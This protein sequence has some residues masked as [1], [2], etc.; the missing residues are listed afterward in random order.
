[1]SSIDT[2]AAKYDL[3]H[4]TGKRLAMFKSCL[5]EWKPALVNTEWNPHP[6]ELLPQMRTPGKLDFFEE[7]EAFRRAQFAAFLHILHEDDMGLWFKFPGLLF[8]PIRCGEETRLPNV[9]FVARVFFLEALVL[10]N[11]RFYDD[12][13]KARIAEYFDYRWPEYKGRRITPALVDDWMDGLACK[14]MMS[15]FALWSA[16]KAA[17]A[18]KF[19]NFV[20]FSVNLKGVRTTP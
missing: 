1:M 6:Y 7:Q 20:L 5:A 9:K 18:F 3:F 10:L 13:W 12:D 16:K 8:A 19:V 2:E 15:F 4:P 14:P 17:N 11:E